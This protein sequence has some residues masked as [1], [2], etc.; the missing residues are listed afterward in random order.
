M[1][2]PAQSSSPTN[3]S[4]SSSDLDT[5]ST[6]SFFHDRSTTLGTL[7]GLTFRAPP[8]NTNS[9]SAVEPSRRAV[10]SKRNINSNA[11]D[12]VVSKRRRRWWNF[13]SHGDSRSASLGEFL[14]V[15]RRFGD[16]VFYETAA[17]LEGLVVDSPQQRSSGRAL[18]ADGR[19][20]PPS[21]VEERSSTAG[22]LCGRFPVSITGICSS[23]AG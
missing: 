12:F 14:E 19:I 23:G 6:G 4:I 22:S 9:P 15:E 13:C 1:L 7:I 3:S 21:D 5:Q 18:F 17:E 20:L 2:D 10:K 11:A 16:A 8:H